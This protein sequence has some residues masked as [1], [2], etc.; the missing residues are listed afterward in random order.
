VD[1]LPAASGCDDAPVDDA[2]ALLARE[3]ASLV[4]RLRPWPPARWAAAVSGAGTRADVAHHLAQRLAD[5]A[6]RLEGQ[7]LRPLPRLETDLALPDQLA[8]TADDLVRAGPRDALALAAVAHVL[9]HRRQLLG[10]EPPAGL[11]ARL[12]GDADAAGR[13]V[14]EATPP[15]A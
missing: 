8:V 12:G 7:P 5:D 6:A 13:S 14:C 2:V 11:V 10:E 15:S 4:E 1:G 9:W 3:A